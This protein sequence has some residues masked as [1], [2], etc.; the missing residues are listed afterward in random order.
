MLTNRIGVKEDSKAGRLQIFSPLPVISANPVSEKKNGMSEPTSAPQFCRSLL[1][2]LLS[3]NL[4]AA[5]I[6]VAALLLPPPRPAP[7]SHLKKTINI[8]LLN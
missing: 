7:T 3:D 8:K 6:A 4:F 2:A 5:Y 1:L